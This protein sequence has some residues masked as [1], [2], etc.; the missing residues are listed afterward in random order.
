MPKKNLAVCIPSGKLVDFGFFLSYVQS[1][2]QMLLSWN[3]A[4]FAVSSPMIFENRNEIVR[5]LLKFEEKNGMLFDY[6]L[7]I[8]NDIMFTFE[9]VQRLIAALDGGADFV[10]GVY[11]NPHGGTIKPVAYM[12]RGETYDWLNENDI[13]SD[14]GLMEVDSVGFGFCAM[15]AQLVRKMSEKFSPRPFELRPLPDG[16]L[17]SEDQLFC[18]RAKKEFGTKIL[19]DPS[20]V[21]RHAKGYLPR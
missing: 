14:G 2:G 4:T 8:D 1:Y 3:T 10:S 9:D 11:Y 16:T 5:R 15:S 6:L 7:W 13:K 21:V 17:V 20:I 18:E 12:A 19:L